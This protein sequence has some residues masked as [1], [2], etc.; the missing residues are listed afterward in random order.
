VNLKRFF[1]NSSPGRLVLLALMLLGLFFLSGRGALSTEETR[2]YDRIR[3]AQDLLWKAMEQ[4]GQTDPAHDTDKTGFIGLEWSE[5]S[6]TLG[7]LEAKRNAGD[8]LWSAQCLRWFD[9]LGLKAGDRIVVL[10]SASFPGLLYSVLA[11]A[12]SRGL[13]VDLVVSLG[14]SAWGANRPEAPWPVMARILREGGFLET[15]PLFYTLGGNN[16]KATDM[17]AEGVD[18]LTKAAQ[19]DGVELFRPARLADIIA[20]KLELLDL[21]G[22]P[23]ARL[24][25]NI[26]GSE[27][28]LGTDETVVS[29]KNGLL[30][31]A[32]AAA[33]GNGIIAMALK[34]DF[35]VLHLL[36][37]RGLAEQVG[38]AFGTRHPRFRDFSP[39]S[40]LVGLAFFLVILAVA[41]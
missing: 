19:R 18:A 15:Q 37:L 34:Q 29:L 28:N 39:L 3:A 21:P 33:A 25:V 8:P 36:N 16:E 5:T 38:I 32:D 7:K 13:H 26:G 41:G 40:A 4:K 17:P 2:L 24:L 14:A 1:D 12:E 22:Q 30:T 20:R 11:A 31:Q 6:T 23:K 27:A 10:S 35:P 9:R